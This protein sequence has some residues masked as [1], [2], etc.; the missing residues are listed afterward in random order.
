MKLKLKLGLGIAWITFGL[1]V[2]FT[3]RLFTTAPSLDNPRGS[4]VIELQSKMSSEGIKAGIDHAQRDM[5]RAQSEIKDIKSKM[6]WTGQA[7]MAL[8][9]ALQDA[10]D[11]FRSSQRQM[12]SLVDSRETMLT[13][14]RALTPVFSELA[15]EETRDLFAKRQESHA[16]MSMT[17]WKYDMFFQLIFGGIDREG[18]VLAQIGGAIVQLLMR[19]SFG[20][21][22][23][24]V[25]FAIRLPFWIKEYQLFE[26]DDTLAG[27]APATTTGGSAS[28]YEAMYERLEGQSASRPEEG[29]FVGGGGSWKSTI[30]ATGFWFL[31][32]T[33][34]SLATM[35]ILLLIWS[36]VIALLVF[37]FWKARQE[38]GGRPRP[39]ARADHAPPRREAVSYRSRTETVSHRFNQTEDPDHLD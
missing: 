36:P 18:N 39:A 11:R 38:R 34:A 21:V 17:M 30:F 29:R 33:G 20:S 9:V 16:G 25:D 35:G 37:A 1:L 4:K 24:L 26:E 22:A 32:I 7:P 6:P 12:L 27:F 13:Q 2:I 28:G 31:A 8:T 14:I 23:A 5:T 10:E 3:P 19:L 15:W